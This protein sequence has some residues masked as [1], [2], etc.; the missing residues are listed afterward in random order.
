M[1][2][3][4]LA[5]HTHE[6]VPKTRALT[7]VL[8]A[9]PDLA[10]LTVA[11]SGICSQALW[12][13]ASE[14]QLLSVLAAMTQYADEFGLV[15]WRNPVYGS[16]KPLTPIDAMVDRGFH[17]ALAVLLS[18]EWDY[19]IDIEGY[20]YVLGKVV[21]TVPSLAPVILANKRL[22]KAELVSSGL[23]AA[24]LAG[25]TECLPML[26]KGKLR[27]EDAWYAVYRAS[28]V[29]HVNV[30][31]ALLA[32]HRIR[33]R[34]GENL[35]STALNAALE[36]GDDAMVAQ[37]MQPDILSASH[38]TS[39]FETAIN[40]GQLDVVRKLLT[41]PSLV[42][43]AKVL[44]TTGY[45]VR[46]PAIDP[47]SALAFSHRV[48]NNVHIVEIAQMILSDPRSAAPLLAD[49]RAELLALLPPVT[50]SAIAAAMEPAQTGTSLADSS[51]ASGADGGHGVAAHVQNS[52]PEGAAAE[53]PP[54]AAGQGHVGLGPAAPVAA[55]VPAAAPAELAGDDDDDEESDSSQDEEGEGDNV[56][57][58]G[59]G[60]NG[61]SQAGR[62]GPQPLGWDW[63]WNRVLSCDF[64]ACEERWG[65][66]EPYDSY[67]DD[68]TGLPKAAPKAEA[69]KLRA[70]AAEGLAWTPLAVAESGPV[71]DLADVD[72]TRR[73]RWGW[74]AAG[75]AVRVEAVILLEPRYSQY[76]GRGEAGQWGYSIFVRDSRPT[77]G[78]FITGVMNHGCHPTVLT[79]RWRL[80]NSDGSTQDALFDGTPWEG[81]TIMLE[82]PHV[83][84]TTVVDAPSIL[85]RAAAGLV[86]YVL[87]GQH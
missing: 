25:T 24:G 50:V 22:K 31:A 81:V 54:V 40:M 69:A 85:R 12:E 26:L 32:D 33:P 61:R 17:R 30:V 38:V 55:P 80:E 3:V 73:V 71:A 75:G 65:L 16:F 62:A 79:S 35:A 44:V 7:R 14:E 46:R 64:I 37:L 28:L 77:A 29:G 48:V 53:V 74:Q 34:K 6:V 21:G 20:E 63:D 72:A 56:D 23:L 18:P 42:I 83:P 47:A 49:Q 51:G 4:G 1:T 36:R 70:L 60:S 68:T 57:G 59:G 8:A 45:I 10:G 82:A 43:T 19:R 9:H 66:T 27:Q 67:C 52:P 84:A 58:G 13:T 15:E 5:W 76:L 78:P 87:H 86:A 11:I 41:F 39:A 2:L